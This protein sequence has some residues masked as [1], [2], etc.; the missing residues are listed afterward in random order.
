MTATSG[1]KRTGTAARLR[2]GLPAFAMA[3]YYLD[4]QSV[5]V[6]F[7]KFQKEIPSLIPTRPLEAGEQYW[8]HFDMTRCI[9]CKCCVVACNEQNGNPAAVHWRR[10]GELEGGH[11]PT[12]QRHHLSLIV[13]INEM[14]T[15]CPDGRIPWC[16]VAPKKRP[17]SNKS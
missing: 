2:K 3:L 14:A 4:R 13:P 17:G 11:Y 1:S 12:V 15:I 8:F 6:V 5:G 16:R 9:G 7:A 10:V